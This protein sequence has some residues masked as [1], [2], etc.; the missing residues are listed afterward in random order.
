MEYYLSYNNRDYYFEGVVLRIG[1]NSPRNDI[2]IE[3]DSDFLTH[4]HYFWEMV[5]F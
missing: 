1:Y 5:E 2:V 4:E 3:Y